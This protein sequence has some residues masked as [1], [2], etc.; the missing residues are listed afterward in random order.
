[1]GC[2][3]SKLPLSE[4]ADGTPGTAA[5]EQRDETTAVGKSY[6][7]VVVEL[8]PQYRDEALEPERE[9]MA[10]ASPELQAYLRIRAEQKGA[11]YVY[12]DFVAA[13]QKS[14]NE[15]IGTLAKRH[16]LSAQI[17]PGV[18]EGTTFN[19]TALSEGGGAG[20][21]NYKL[22]WEN[23]ADKSASGEHGAFVKIMHNSVQD[24]GI[25]RERAGAMV[26]FAAE[27]TP[28]S[29]YCLTDRICITEDGG[30][31]LEDKA[32]KQEAELMLDRSRATLQEVAT[33]VAKIHKVDPQWFNEHRANL[34]EAI[35]LLSEATPSSKLWTLARVDY[36]EKVTSNPVAFRALAKFDVQERLVSEAARRLVTTHGDFHPGNMVRTGTSIK[37]IDL[38]AVS[39]GLAVVDLGAASTPAGISKDRGLFKNWTLDDKREY[40]SAY[41][42]AM[43]DPSSM[44]DADCLAIDVLTAHFWWASIWGIAWFAYGFPFALDKGRNSK[45]DNDEHALAVYHSSRDIMALLI[46]ARAIKTSA[47]GSG[48]LVEEIVRSGLSRTHRRLQTSYKERFVAAKKE[49]PEGWIRPEWRVWQH[50]APSEMIPS[51]RLD[52]A[53][54]VSS[55]TDKDVMESARLL[56]VDAT[57]TLEIMKQARGDLHLGTL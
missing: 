19:A 4:A 31:N 45:Y 10:G 35:P 49:N 24:I 39:A 6:G 51:T 34:C 21:T 52:H 13:S 41:L 22:K 7:A 37:A 38:E 48:P 32:K 33:L 56:K 1:M 43:G 15:L 2:G 11:K 53:L 46:E 25:K 50:G 40:Y 20:G 42:R 36:L 30:Q 29:L 17:W 55:M 3:A 54:L 47:N 9:R 5:V 27:A 18:H 57:T 8:F 12:D 26:L 14:S 16:L 23:P 28:R 44:I